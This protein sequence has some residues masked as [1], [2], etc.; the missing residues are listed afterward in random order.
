[1]RYPILSYETS[2]SAKGD[3]REMTL[4]SYMDDMQAAK[5]VF[6]RFHTLFFYILLIT[7][8][9]ISF[10]CRWVLIIKQNLI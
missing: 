5:R 6:S 7:V 10:P 3:Q 1:M 2:Y 4:L 9:K 8:N